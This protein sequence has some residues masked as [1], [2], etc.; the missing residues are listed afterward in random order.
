VRQPD[1]TEYRVTQAA[2]RRS[3]GF[4]SVGAS[5]GTIASEDGTLVLAVPQGAISGQ[6][7]IKMSHMAE[8]E[9][10]IPRDDY[11]SPESMPFA[12]G[13]R[14]EPQGQFVCTKELH[15]EV[16]IP[17]GVSVTEGQRVAFMKPAK[18]N[19]EGQQV[20]VFESLTSGKV[21]NGRFKT[22]SA[23]FLGI[24]LIPLQMLM[25][26]V[27]IPRNFYAVHGVV[28]EQ[29]Y[30]QAS[31][32]LE[33]V[34][35]IIPAKDP[36]KQPRL[37]S[38]TGSTG[39]YGIF[40]TD[41]PVPTAEAKLPSQVAVVA[42]DQAGRKQIGIA[43]PHFNINPYL[44]PGLD[45]LHTLYAAIEFPSIEAGE[46]RPANI[47]IDGRRADV[48]QGQPDSLHDLGV[49]P[50]GTPIG[51]IVGTNPKVQ[52]FTGKLLVGGVESQNLVWTPQP[53]N[54]GFEIRTTSLIVPSEG[55]Y[56][57]QVETHTVA[58]VEV[59]KAKQTY[60]F[61]ALRNPNTRQPLPGSPRVLTVSPPDK[62]TQVDATS[63]IHLEFSEPV[64]HL[65]AG[66]SV[67]LVE[68]NGSS[69][70]IGG[71]ISSGG[72]PLSSDA[73]G[74][75]SV[76][77]EPF[78]LAGG[79]QYEVHVTGEVV[80]SDGNALDQDQTSPTDTDSQPFVSTFKTFEGFALTDTGVAD[81]GFRVA[82]AGQYAATIQMQTANASQ[83]TVYDMSNPR[84]PAIQY[85][86]FIPQRAI[87]IAMVE[88]EPED[89]FRVGN[90]KNEYTR[91]AFVTTNA[92]P[93]ID[94][95]TNMWIFNLEDP[96]KPEIV[97]VVS[98]AFL[99]NVTAVPACITIHKKRAYIGN[100]SQTGLYV[101]DI[102]QA[103][104]DWARAKLRTPNFGPS[105]PQVLAVSPNKGFDFEA[106]VQS[107]TYTA[108][109]D[110]RNSPISSISVIDQLAIQAPVAYVASPT[111]SKL[112]SFLL[113]PETDGRTGYVD[114]Q[115]AGHDDRRLA[116]MDLEPA[117]L[118]QDVRAVQKVNVGGKNTDLA[119]ILGGNRLWIF[120]VT[121]PFHPTQYPSRSFAEMGL[122]VGIPRRMDVEGTLAYVFF[123]DQIVVF[124]F[125][126][127]TKPVRVATLTGVGT[128]ISGLTVK[129]GFI[130]SLSP[131][132]T[133][134]EG[135]NVSI[136]RPASQLIAYGVNS[137][138][139]QVCTNPV[140]ISRGSSPHM[141]QPVGLFFQVFGHDLPGAAQVVIRK[142]KTV[143]GEKTE[144]T[145]ATV[146]AVINKDLSSDRIVVGK[147]Q[148]SSTAVIDRTA[149]YTAELV[150][151]QNSSSEFRSR[152]EQIA[153]ST[154][155]T[156]SK[157]EFGTSSGKGFYSYILS[158]NA[159]VT[160][161]VN[162]QNLLADANDPHARSYG[163]NVDQVV[164]SLPEGTYPFTLRA[165]LVDNP[166]V[167]DEVEGEMRVAN[168]QEDLRLP[169]S[170]MVNGVELSTGNLAL[171]YT[172]VAIKNRGLS[173]TFARSYNSA[174]ANTFGP[175][176][177]G[178]RHNFQV[179]LSHNKN[180]KAFTIIGGDG[181]GQ[182]FL[183][184]KEANGKMLAEDPF[185][186]TLVRN[187]NGSFDY[188]T[189]S[190][191]KY[192]FP[193][194][195]EEDAFNFF[196]VAYMGNLEYM[197]EP[198]GNR[199]TLAFDAQGRMTSVT[200]SSQR[201][202][203]FTYAVAD[204]PFVGV[205]SPTSGNTISCTNK[206][207]FS[208]LRNRF[209]RADIGKAWHI[210]KMTGPGGFEMDYDYDADGNLISA[211]RPA[212]DTLSQAAPSDAVWQYDYNPATS[213]TGAQP[214]H[215]LKSVTG[216]NDTGD[217]KHKTSYDYHFDQFR[218]PVKSISFP[219]SVANRFSYTL[220]SQNRVTQ[221]VAV[222]GRSNATTYNFD[223]Y[224]HATSIV[225][226]RNARTEMTWNSK[227]LMET[228]R[229][230]EGLLTTILYEQGNP[231][232]TT[233]QGGSEHTQVTTRYNAKFSKPESVKDG[234]GNVT[235]YT[236]D[237][238]GNVR[239]SNLPT[240]RV[241]LLDYYPNG[242]LR[243]VADQYGLTTTYEYDSYGNPTLI[244]RET[245]SGSPVVTRN[246]YDA[247]SRLKT[248]EDTL[249]PSVSYTYDAFD[250]VVQ[251]EAN[252]PTGIRDAFSTNLTYS[253]GGQVKTARQAGGDLSMDIAFTYDNLDRMTVRSE[254]ISGAGHFD[255]RYSYDENSN[256]LTES[257]RRGAVQTHT[258]DELNFRTKTTLS[259]SFGPTLTLESVT[260]NLLGQPV[261]ITNLYGQT[262][263]F[264]YDGLHRLK[265]R[266]LP[267]GYTE[268]MLYDAN[269]NLVS[270][271]DRNGRETAMKYDAVN[272]PAQQTDPAGRVTS[273]VYDDATKTVTIQQTPQGLTKI[274]KTDGLNRP[275]REELKFSDADYVT[276][277]T[278]NGRVTEITD[279]RN[280]VTRRTASAFGETGSLDVV[281]ASPAWNNELRYSAFGGMKSRKDANSRLTT[282]T[283][284]ALNRVTAA[285]YP[286]SVSEAF[287]YDGEGNMLSH[288]DRRGVLSQFTY[289]N[290]GRPLT[291]KV[292]NGA[293]TI[294]VSSIAYDDATSTESITDAMT[295]TT[296][297]QYDGLHRRK[298]VTNAE[299]A[300][301][302]Y[303]YDGMNLVRESD[304]KSQ[305]TYFKYDAVDRLSQVKD[306]DGKV[307]TINNADGNGTTRT[308]TDRRG[309]LR[310]ETYDPLG[311]LTRVTSGGEL[312]YSAKYDGDNNRTFSTDG[313]TNPTTYEYDALN[314][315]KTIKHAAIQMESYEYDA[316]GNVKSYSDGAGSPLTM[317]YDPMDHL[318][319]RT[320]GEH[321]T[322]R[323]KYDGEGLLREKTEPKGEQ[324]KTL[325]EYNALGSLISVT[326]ADHKTWKLDY[327]GD[328]TLKSI[329][330]PLG[331]SVTYGYDK[332]RRLK[333][334]TQHANTQS[335]FQSTFITA[336]DYDAN[337]NRTSVQDPK[338]QMAVIGYDNL[339]R[340]KTV[341]YSNVQG[342]G[343]RREQYD[344]DPE[345]NVTAISETIAG[346]TNPLTS[347]R[348][349]ARTYDE[350]NRL[351]SATDPYGRKV[352]Y[353][354]DEANNVKELTDAANKQTSYTYDALNRLEHVTMDGGASAHYT[355]KPDGMLEK[356][357]Y[358]TGL[359]RNYNYDGADRLLSVKNSLGT[360]QLNQPQTEEF[361]YTY[362][363]N[364]NRQ[365]ET[366][367]YG[368]Q[369]FRSASYDYD[370]VDRLSQAD[371]TNGA[372]S[373]STGLLGQYF[374][375]ADLTNQLATRT[376]AT[377]DFEWP[378]T[379]QPASGVN[380]DSFSVRWSGQ[381]RPAY[382][383]TYTFYAAADEGVRLWVN[384]QLI[385]DNWTNQTP[386]E[387][388]GSITLVAGQ[389]YDLKLEVTDHGGDASARLL[390][391]SQSQ[392]KEVVPSSRLNPPPAADAS[393]SLHYTYDA[394]GNRKTKTG[395][396][397]NGAP[398]NQ[399]YDYDDLNRLTSSNN[400]G[401]EYSYE[402]DANGNLKKIMQGPLSV[403]QY[404]YD[405]RNQLRRV[406]GGTGQE[407]AHYDYDVQRRRIG[408][409][410]G[411]GPE[412][413]DVYDGDR[414]VNQFG[415]DGQLVNR[416]DY[417]AGLLRG[418][419][420]GEGERWYFSDGQG[421]VTSLSQ[422][423]QG[424][425]SLQAQVATRYEY[426]PWGQV[427]GGGGGS[428][429]Q[430]LY[431]GQR[432]DAE[433]GLMAL[434]NGERYYSPGLGRFIQQD[435]FTGMA[436]SA[437][438]M[439]R[440]AYV[441]NNPLRYRDPTGHY[442][443][444]DLG[445]DILSVLKGAGNA[446]SGILEPFR[447]VADVVT[448]GG[449]WAMGIDA[450]Y[451]QLSSALGN[452]EKNAV[453]SGQN[454]MDVA[455]EGSHQV[456]FGVFTLGLGPLAKNQ[457][458]LG[459]A[460][461]NGQMS[462]EDYNRASLENL[463]GA[464]TMLALPRVAERIGGGGEAPGR[465]AVEV[466]RETKVGVATEISPFGSSV[467]PTELSSGTFADLTSIERVQEQ[468]SRFSET[469][470]AIREMEKPG[471]DA[472][473]QA[474]GENGLTLM[475]DID[476][477]GRLKIWK[478]DF[479]SA[480][481]HTQAH[482]ADIGK[483]RNL[484]F[485][486]L[487]TWSR[488][489]DTTLTIEP[490]YPP[491][492]FFTC[493]PIRVVSEKLMQTLD[494]HLRDICPIEAS[495]QL[496][497]GY[498]GSA[499]R[500]RLVQEQ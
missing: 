236:L 26:M 126:D 492:D 315:L 310:V 427:I 193:G 43:T 480:K 305:S 287:T 477:I 108:S 214:V 199:L 494:S 428:V 499:I 374:D 196:N 2:Y 433:T 48:E 326:D 10:T 263:G 317:T 155:I 339:D 487:D 265:Q 328:Q 152:R 314:R 252:D 247:R 331:R 346:S 180:S 83:L 239:T 353:R 61:I 391:S 367:K 217:G 212:Q 279:P 240:G 417:G 373:T 1:G 21:E 462:L 291:S 143:N 475:M 175:L 410:V 329:S 434:G 194:A 349:Y 11:M 28:T 109:A 324:Y 451:V 383:E 457:I 52:Q 379:T 372:S 371:F 327:Y 368:G 301:K 405:A 119:V 145:L 93:D 344:Y 260:P 129:D 262:I 419:M 318:E 296:V 337:G 234:M 268:A 165:A 336:Y 107:V 308:I 216:P 168:T 40:L 41:G 322:T 466:A 74:I 456:L 478:A 425:S 444:S 201:S 58:N 424:A 75:S 235:T 57:L 42:T 295:H 246:S 465:N 85:R 443:L 138:S 209:N 130:Y 34:K 44:N 105:H 232:S 364:S 98:M 313:R 243:S 206:N 288:A 13:V 121:D 141:L 24:L 461:N 359:E 68:T 460:Y 76:D 56:T 467:R 146:Q 6:A 430:F 245:G 62:A 124:D 437:Q 489:P 389:K 171:T 18:V 37:T 493:G 178:W 53:E 306:R 17:N 95:P 73:P 341:D 275:Q 330:D 104:N 106:K 77:F 131:G 303:E 294:N 213:Q 497:V 289:D 90:P 4:T 137:N 122:Q 471:W 103:M 224:R 411:G 233:K 244:T 118:V 453:L 226:P 257:D 448:A 414:V 177:Y 316:V 172:D 319:T 375:S 112:I 207:Q 65:I 464:L 149:N 187:G 271:K 31:K 35:V 203:N 7:D 251:T 266:S 445:D 377:V 472:H 390:W 482:F 210:T 282:Y 38:V 440:Y 186:G 469:F 80:D 429:N 113:R 253:P 350:R 297:V 458:E 190:Y 356:V 14:I 89:A 431:T 30:G 491:A 110:D 393:G 398:V 358:G 202:L 100:I 229:D 357:T 388:S 147:A 82:A 441:Q 94:R 228:Q 136:A 166:S 442:S 432:A 46:A 338:G 238:R 8:S 498:R 490:P 352:S 249:G 323:F 19:W 382:S 347:T 325:Y 394:V 156:A 191:V 185:Q 278:Y 86:G 215:L 481:F 345:G 396:E 285:S 423:T 272:R 254:T 401:I 222:D 140:V 421:S 3:N 436:M 334:L 447:W 55:S 50:V 446:L 97:G 485:Y 173:L 250:R 69:D 256:L 435:S 123:T 361:N 59:T 384:G 116:F 422:I 91:L 114:T 167:T 348:S 333:T 270:S 195:M 64:K 302:S 221:A 332:V 211:T 340:A 182:R 292:Q 164:H 241:V 120:D 54:S 184:S 286:G 376:D 335:S 274:V 298:S 23:P 351:A 309:N 404:E 488:F 276:S 79:K 101:I 399:S 133:G 474:I 153:F 205:I 135:L 231:V 307:T 125:S 397:I 144:E 88:T 49:V 174:G 223:N 495:E 32:P 142:E 176:G 225:G 5:G 16:N 450:E 183:E 181:S 27:F 380:G 67:Y 22:M 439:N 115:S 455:L 170:M 355:W 66:Q 134:H 87:A 283:V 406:T 400:G 39:G 132:S 304:F 454:P 378:G 189:K 369:M 386:A 420:K 45:G 312:L 148:W 248:T 273:W 63:K 395:R 179:L 29:V 111:K 320:D 204:T 264:E 157:Q 299:L 258:Y 259:G 409:S 370:V 230:P 321:N 284:D 200:D 117:G 342:A 163:L 381:V 84:T 418:S 311:R 438:S 218:Q 484:K 293:E 486:S 408:R 9:I 162:G 267:G 92:V 483:V 15:L 415:S 139:D 479:L 160:L 78:G 25:A 242:D 463:G 192:H 403:A 473:M 161:S 343:P 366:K 496:K 468:L 158:G 198:N 452:F 36:A 12:A 154:L 387:S 407:I 70:H 362:D 470:E 81:G 280:I 360:D 96:T 261:N 47:I 392:S 281:G 208:I 363:A 197:E 151:D 237:E 413:R 169:G 33:G 255:L 102:E 51:L 219:E 459:I 71:R 227:G 99:N 426:D 402:Y 188:F 150:L 500:P 128:N 365:T 290:L 385:I 269:N 220:D 416:Y 449:A 72:I 300:V 127:P 60:N 277:Y 159:M 354:Y 20:D 412:L 476:T